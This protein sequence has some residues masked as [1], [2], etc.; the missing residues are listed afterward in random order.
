MNE[1][2]AAKGI[3]HVSKIGASG[4]Q[5][6]VRLDLSEYRVGAPPGALCLSARAELPTPGPLAVKGTR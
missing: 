6:V 4:F 3:T 5:W 1:V 2:V